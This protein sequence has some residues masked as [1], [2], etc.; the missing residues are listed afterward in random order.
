MGPLKVQLNGSIAVNQKGEVVGSLSLEDG[1][2]RLIKI[3][4]E[5]T[6]FFSEEAE[7]IRTNEEMFDGG[8]QEEYRGSEGYARFAEEHSGEDMGDTLLGQAVIA[9]DLRA[10]AQEASTTHIDP[11]TRAVI[12]QDTAGNTNTERTSLFGRCI[13]SVFHRKKK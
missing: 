9:S 4:S 7:K 2:N 13:P 6:T 11:G 5:V 8:L 12:P 1:N 10:Y 3:D